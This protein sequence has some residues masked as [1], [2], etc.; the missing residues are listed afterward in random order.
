V[1]H[2]VGPV[3]HG[4]DQ[5]EEELLAQCYRSSMRL[6]HE[7]G[8]RS[9]AFPSISTGVYG[10]P[11]HLAADIAWWELHEAAMRYPEIRPIRVVAHGHD[12]LDAY[13][14]AR[15]AQD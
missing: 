12:T 9:I 1:I 7:N 5:G 6:A 11:V 2:T 15:D 10:Y 3:W 13:R 4:G 8:V 14:E